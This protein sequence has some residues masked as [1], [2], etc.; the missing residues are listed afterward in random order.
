MQLRQYQRDA[1]DS[2]YDYFS[3]ADGNPLIVMPTGTGKSVVIAGFLREAIEG[4]SDTRV[5][6]LTHVKE[7]IQ[8]NFAALLRMW[9]TAPAGIYSAGL[10]KRDLHAQILFGGIQSIY[11]RAYAVQRCDLVLIDEAHLLS[12]SDSGMYRTFLTALRE[13]N[14]AVKVIG[15]TATPYRM[16]TGLLHEG[17]NR[18]FTDICY[19]IPILKMIEQ[20]YLCPVVPKR[21][22]TQLD[23]GGVGT[24]GG[25]FIARD[26]ERAVDLADVNAAA[27]DEIVTLGKDRGSWL[28]F[29]SGVAHAEHIRDEIQ[30]RGIE[31]EAVLGETTSTARDRILTNFKAGRLRALTNANVLTTGFDAP[32][33]D[34]IGLLRPTKSVGL[35]VQMLGRGTRLAEGKENCLILDFAGNT[36]RHG[37]LDTVDGRTRKEPGEGDAPVKECPECQTICHASVRECPTCGFAFPPPQ[38]KI[39]AIAS[40]KAILSTQVVAEWVEVSNVSYHRHEKPGGVPSMRVDYWCGLVKHSEWVCFEHLPTS[41]PRQKAC[42]WWHKRAPSEP[43]PADVAEALAM[44]QIGIRTPVAIQ[45]KPVGKYTE[46]L[47]VHFGE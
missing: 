34:L 22:K 9:P 41:Y 24:R 5:L 3:G 17:E 28:I 1:I 16:K 37:P 32:G 33:V 19:D 40:D 6:V 45:V 18:I 8:Q 39:D 31:C 14:P 2:I 20:G 35:Y 27:V 25:E 43:V 44:A 23:V 7:L 26:L 42:S 29:C 13:I 36:A 11:K 38:V 4:W 12:E 46:I 15:F 30:S 21:T 47:A 10:N